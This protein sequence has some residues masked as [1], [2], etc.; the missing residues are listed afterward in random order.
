[1]CGRKVSPAHIAAQSGRLANL[2]M[3]HQLHPGLLLARDVHERC[4]PVYVCLLLDTSL[5]EGLHSYQ[6]IWIRLL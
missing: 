6:T 5:C 3:L 4:L 2:Q 1:V